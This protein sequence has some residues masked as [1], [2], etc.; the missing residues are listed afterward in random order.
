MP[1]TDRV[2]FEAVAQSSNMFQVPRLIRWQYKLEP[3]QVLKVTISDKNAPAQGLHFYLAKTTKAGRIRIPK[4]LVRTFKTDSP[5]L[6]GHLLHVT[7]E[8]AGLSSIDT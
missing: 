4:L 3:D 5:N 6:A 2:S 8:P 7:L 1:L